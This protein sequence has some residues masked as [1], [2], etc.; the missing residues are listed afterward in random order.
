MRI[1]TKS[2]VLVFVDEANICLSA[3]RNYNKTIDWPKFR[4]YLENYGD[5]PR[6][7][8]EMV[9]YAGLPPATSDWY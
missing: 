8:V 4:D 1:E 7:I 2:R 9:I 3:S 5:G 6:E